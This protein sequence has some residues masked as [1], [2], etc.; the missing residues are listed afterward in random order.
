M[1]HAVIQ[2]FTARRVQMTNRDGLPH[3][4][5]RLTIFWILILA[6]PVMRVTE[7]IWR[8]E[9]YDDVEN[10]AAALVF[11]AFLLGKVLYFNT[12]KAVVQRLNEIERCWQLMGRPPLELIRG[13]DQ[14]R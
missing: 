2:A 6:W 14:D 9:W 4:W 5:A 7:T 8:P 13:G 1:P 12:Q 3:E 10:A 11:L